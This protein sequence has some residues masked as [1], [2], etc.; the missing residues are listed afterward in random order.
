MTLI[1]MMVVSSV[2]MILALAMAT[3]LKN[4]GDAQNSIRERAE[5]TNIEAATR[6]SASNITAVQRSMLVKEP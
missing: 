2:M 1:E 3:F 6:G 5:R 4:Q